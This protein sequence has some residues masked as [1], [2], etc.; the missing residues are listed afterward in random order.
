MP[1]K[2]GIPTRKSDSSEEGRFGK[3]I[4]AIIGSLAALGV[5]SAITAYYLPGILRS[6]GSL[7]V[8]RAPI[9]YSESVLPGTPNY[10]FPI[11]YPP[12]K[13]PVSLL[14]NI[15]ERQGINAFA[16][17]AGRHGGIVV[18][19][20][21]QLILRA[22]DSSPVIINNISVQIIRQKTAKG[23]WFNAWDGC[24]GVVDVRTL[25]VNLDKRP[26]SV[27]WSDRSSSRI[28]PPTL[29][30]TD[31]DNEVIDVQV[32]STR[33][34]IIYWVIQISYSAA[35]SSGM[36]RIDNHGA[37]FAVTSLRN[38]VAYTVDDTTGR[39]LRTTSRDGGRDGSG[40]NYA[41]T[42]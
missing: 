23:G 39:L 29:E 19:P 11:S 5:I 7:I 1:R 28:K 17:W 9:Y 41:D 26:F 3:R 21:V 12:S 10:V 42:C 27:I 2:Q 25:T 18:A 4:K 14:H 15:F 36:M 31:T 32:Y 13:V 35:S 38:S 40:Y 33:P 6:G 34:K 20:E 37:P 22:R 24:G 16:D 8:K 30:V